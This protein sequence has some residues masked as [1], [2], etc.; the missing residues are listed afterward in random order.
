MDPRKG[1]GRSLGCVKEAGGEWDYAV[2]QDEIHGFGPRSWD[3]KECESWE[4]GEAAVY[5]KYEW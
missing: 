2:D 4:A 5:P 3:K 1:T